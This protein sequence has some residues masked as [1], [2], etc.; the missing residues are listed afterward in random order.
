MEELPKWEA[1]QE[2]K[3]AHSGGGPTKKN[4]LSPMTTL[5]IVTRAEG[6]PE[7]TSLPPRGSGRVC[8]HFT[9]SNPA[10]G[11]IPGLWLKQGDKVTKFFHRVATSHKRY[12]SIESLMVDGCNTKM[13]LLSVKR[14]S[15]ASTKICTKNQRSGGLSY[16]YRGLQTLV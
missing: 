13:T 14:P 3:N 1:V 11:T 12:N 6:L 16:S 7:S 15:K 8:V 4:W 10:L 9:L 5:I 2:Q